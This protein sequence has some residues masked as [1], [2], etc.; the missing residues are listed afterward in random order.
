MCKINIEGSMNQ[1]SYT[2][3][4]KRGDGE[5]GEE[6]EVLNIGLGWGGGDQHFTFILKYMQQNF[7]GKNID[8]AIFVKKKCLVWTIVRLIYTMTY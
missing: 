8:K 1:N 3:W 5:I 7:L 2:E 6:K 4:K